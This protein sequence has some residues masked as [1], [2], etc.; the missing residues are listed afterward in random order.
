MAMK[1]SLRPLVALLALALGMG[2]VVVIGTSVGTHAR[3]YTVAAVQDSL[4]RRPAAWVGWVVGVRGIAVRSGCLSW[5]SPEITTCQGWGQSILLDPGELTALPLTL[6]APNP[7]LALLSR[8]PLAGRLLPPP[9]AVHW[10]AVTTYWVQLRAAPAGSCPSSP[11]YRALLLD[12]A[13]D[14]LGR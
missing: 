1:H 2:G 11:C 10:G 12:A 3:V 8:L 9:Q 5:P 4:A 6:G 14:G 7:L 13:R